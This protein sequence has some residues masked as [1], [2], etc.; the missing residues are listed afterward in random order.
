MKTWL[1]FLTEAK[2]R[3]RRSSS[4]TPEKK[5][6]YNVSSSGRIGRSKIGVPSSACQQWRTEPGSFIRIAREHNRH[7]RDRIRRQQRINLDRIEPRHSG[8]QR[9]VHD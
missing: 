6:A 9:V 4:A 1:R 2:K 7:D 3:S 8:T 5:S